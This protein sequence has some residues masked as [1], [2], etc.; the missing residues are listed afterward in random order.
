MHSGRK[1]TFEYRSKNYIADIMSVLH[2]KQ[3]R[4]ITSTLN[5]HCWH[6]MYDMCSWTL[7]TFNSIQ[8]I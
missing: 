4:D 5:V 8:F 6:Y 7:S 1:S 2:Y 3:I